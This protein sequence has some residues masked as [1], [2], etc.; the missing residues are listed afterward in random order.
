MLQFALIVDYNKILLSFRT[1]LYF[2]VPLFQ[3]LD[4]SDVETENLE[5]FFFFSKNKESLCLDCII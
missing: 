1:L 2:I 3:N 5:I 4:I